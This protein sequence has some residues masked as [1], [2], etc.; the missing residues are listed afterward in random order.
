MAVDPYNIGIQMKQKE[1]TKKF[2]KKMKNPLWSPQFI[3]K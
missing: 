3:Q 1:P 2:M